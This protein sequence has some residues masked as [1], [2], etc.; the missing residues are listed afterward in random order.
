MRLK[1]ILKKALQKANLYNGFILNEMSNAHI[2]SSAKIIVKENVIIGEH[3]I[4]KE[5]VII[6]VFGR[7]VV[8]KG[9]QINPYTVIY[10]GNIQ[11][12]NGVM[13]APH[14]MIAS[15][16]HDYIQKE[17]PMIS[18][19]E[20]TK[21]PIIIGNDVW[22]GAHSTICDGVI[23]GDGAVIAAGSV[24]TKHVPPYSV[25][26]GVPAKIIKYR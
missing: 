6:Q 9:T 20:L 11:I 21:G 10:G 4:I 1:N 18:A 13:I 7:L 24:V 2:H 19:G 25:V 12:G 23:I 8:G 26:G 15:G 14:V 22:I 5:G 3:S 16:N 17:V